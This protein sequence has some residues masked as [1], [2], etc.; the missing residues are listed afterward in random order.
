MITA[1]AAWSEHVSRPVFTA[2]TAPRPYLF[3]T[4][5]TGNR[6]FPMR[7]RT[8]GNVLSS[9]KSYTMTSSQGTWTFSEI[10]SRSPP[11]L[12]ASL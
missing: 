6:K 3:R 5:R 11:M 4:S 9:S 10:E 8:T 1:T 12:S 7:E 2:L